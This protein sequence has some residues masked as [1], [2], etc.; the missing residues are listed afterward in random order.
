MHYENQKR[1]ILNTLTISPSS[2][3]SLT[4]VSDEGGDDVFWYIVVG[5]VVLELVFV[6]WLEHNVIIVN[7]VEL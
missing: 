4:I 5:N 7:F 3:S 1:K 2:E 6:H